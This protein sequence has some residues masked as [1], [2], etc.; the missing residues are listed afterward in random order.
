MAPTPV[1]LSLAE[2]ATGRMALQPI[3]VLQEARQQWTSAFNRCYMHTM[4]SLSFPTSYGLRRGNY[5]ESQQSDDREH[6]NPTMSVLSSGQA[7]PTSP[8]VQLQAMDSDPI[9]Q[10]REERSWWAARFQHVLREIS[11]QDEL[12]NRVATPTSQ[13]VSERQTSDPFAELSP[14]RPSRPLSIISK[15]RLFKLKK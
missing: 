14:E 9:K 2:R 6:T 11:S 1:Y 4:R 5:L 3:K 13:V 15:S 8:S 7:L 10:E 12:E